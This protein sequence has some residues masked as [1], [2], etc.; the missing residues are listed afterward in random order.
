M[1]LSQSGYGPVL[2]FKI[3]PICGKE[4]WLDNVHQFINVRTS[5]CSKL[6]FEQVYTLCLSQ[7]LIPTNFISCFVTSLLKVNFNRLTEKPKTFK[8][9][10]GRYKSL[11]Y[12][13]RCTKILMNSKNRHIITYF[14]TL[15]SLDRF[16][17]AFL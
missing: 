6:R 2:Y 16:V 17:Q 13:L 7:V 3:H 9:E 14:L 10:N 15:V 1:S 11:L 5:S 12:V 8:A 4:F